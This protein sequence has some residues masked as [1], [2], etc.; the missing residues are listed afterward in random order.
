MRKATASSSIVHGPV[1]L[2]RLIH[3]GCAFGEEDSGCERRPLGVGA[4]GALRATHMEKLTFT[5]AL[6]MEWK[7]SLISSSIAAG[8]SGQG[9]PSS[10]P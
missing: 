4:E 2:M 10:A 1:R 7:P 3:Q 6:A 9:R 8:F 5:R